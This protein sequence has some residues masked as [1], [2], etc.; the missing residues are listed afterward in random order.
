MRSGT[1]G[2]GTREQV[3][4]GGP[5][6]PRLLDFLRAAGGQ[7]VSGAR[8]A[9]ALGVSRAAVWKQ[10][11]RLRTEGFAIEARA[12]LG[13]RLIAASEAPRPE[14]VQPHL[15]TQSLG[16]ALRYLCAT[17]STNSDLAALAAAGAPEGMVV[18]AE[19]QSGGRGRLARRWL[20]APGRNL[21]FS[22]LLRPALEP[23]RVTTLPLLA[24]VALARAIEEL[25]PGLGLQIKWPNDLLLG[26]LKLAGILCEMQAEADCVHHVIVGIGLNVNL[27]RSQLPG[28]VR[29][30]ATSLRLA[31]GRDW[32]RAPLLARVLNGFERDYDCWRREGLAPFLGELAARDP[33]AGRRVVIEQGG[34][35]LR[36]V[37]E[38][39]QADGALR[40]RLSDGTL[41]AVVSGDAL[42]D[43]GSVPHA[44]VRKE[45][46]S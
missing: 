8:M 5:A 16:R 25:E 44:H 26:G 3:R 34:R 2:R 30:T 39:I 4:A 23:Q 6:E 21:T 22:M 31:T 45:R 12:R 19:T 9:T 28:E 33:L 46:P 15:D 10:V 14:A 36:G 1:S 38:G 43:P 24:G 40:V 13:Y 37:A 11:E 27:R 7:A 42:A 35:R 29:R 18:V 32:P 20:S 41:Q 17:V